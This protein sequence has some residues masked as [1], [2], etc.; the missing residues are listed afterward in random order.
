MNAVNGTDTKSRMRIVPVSSA[1]SLSYSPAAANRDSSVFATVA[2]DTAK[3]PTGRY[4][5]RSL[6]YS[7][8]A[9]ESPMNPAIRR[10]HWRLS[11]SALAP[12]RPGRISFQIESRVS[13][14][15]MIAPEIRTIM[16]RRHRIRKISAISSTP[17]TSTARPNIF[18]WN[19][20]R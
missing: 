8:A 4:T 11:W 5:R 9:A 16:P 15:R 17:A 14:S 10:S 18:S 6:K 20:P 1:D 2:N 12:S 3:M 19:I 13:R 7:E